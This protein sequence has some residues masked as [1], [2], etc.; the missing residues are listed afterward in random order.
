MYNY[1]IIFVIEIVDYF[2]EFIKFCRCNCLYLVHFLLF[3]LQI[4][5]VWSY[6]L[7]NQLLV[8]LFIN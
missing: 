4:K 3:I 7:R 5:S 6:C 1:L 8:H 2:N